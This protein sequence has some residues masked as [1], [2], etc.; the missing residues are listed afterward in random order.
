L[1]SANPFSPL[2]R[3][4]TDFPMRTTAAQYYFN[5]FFFYATA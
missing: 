3:P 4:Q 1:L 2:A 5:Y